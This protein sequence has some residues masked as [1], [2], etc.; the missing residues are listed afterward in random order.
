[1]SE[2]EVPVAAPAP[3][4]ILP[5]AALALTLVAACAAAG[6][7]WLTRAPDAVLA[8]APPSA[9][10][11]P[12]AE[13]ELDALRSRLDDAAQVNR[14]LRE[15]VLGLTQRVGLVEDGL[16]GMERGAAPG[17]DALRL[18]QADFLLQLGEERLRLLQ[19]VAGARVAYALADAQLVEVSDPRATTVRQTLALER[20]ALAAVASADLPVILGRLDG[21]A[22]GVA[23]W[24]L[25]GIAGPAARSSAPDI[26]WSA[27]LLNTLDRYF[28]VRR[29]DPQERSEG[30]PLLRERLALDLSRTRMLLLRGEPELALGTLQSVRNTVATRFDGS[31]SA[32]AQ[33]LGVLDELIRAPLVPKLPGLG[34]ARRELARLRGVP[35]TRLAPDPAPLPA[36]PATPDAASATPDA[37]AAPDAA[38]SSPAPSADTSVAAPAE[39][40]APVEAVPE[41]VPE[42]APAEDADSAAPAGGN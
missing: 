31:D 16:S 41:P 42:A 13:T 38:A 24:P 21:L 8:P 10:V 34:E 40:T 7:W 30:G 36:A 39:T 9:S 20:D 22:D 18:A 29:V 3:R 2:T 12:A 17:V 28:R 23:H 15:Q 26:A 27:R 1:M 4:R 5:K 35:E 37:P 11:A 32:V 6:W 25:P 33:A 14:A 19:D